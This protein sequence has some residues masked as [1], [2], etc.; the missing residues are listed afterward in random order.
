MGCFLLA[1]A[2]LGLCRIH[3]AS[4]NATSAVLCGC[5]SESEPGGC[6]QLPK[7]TSSVESVSSPGCVVVSFVMRKRGSIAGAPVVFAV[8]LSFLGRQLS[9]RAPNCI[10]VAV[11]TPA[12][13]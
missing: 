1:R 3:A 8:L 10:G 2:C 13:L 4:C 5:L 12:S 11:D 9:P 7:N 6:G